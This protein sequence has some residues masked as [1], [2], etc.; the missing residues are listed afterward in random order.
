MS[1]LRKVVGSH[2]AIERFGVLFLTLVFCMG[3]LVT[4][5]FGKQMEYNSQA[6]SGNA[7]YTR[8]FKMSQTQ[9]AGSVLGVYT[10]EAHTK[11][12]V[13][14]K[15]ADMSLLPVQADEYT[16]FLTGSGKEGTRNELKCSP[17]GMFYLF[18]STGYAGIYLQDVNGFESQILMLYL[19]ATSNFT[20]QTAVGNYTD[21]TFETYNQAAIYFNPG[22]SYATHANF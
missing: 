7:I 13:L 9:T 6:L 1:F 15:F 20:G 10:N 21:K 18:G 14:L 5:I 4:S 2:Y 17:S 19:R 11:C 22:G 12:L 16:M 8:S 3:L